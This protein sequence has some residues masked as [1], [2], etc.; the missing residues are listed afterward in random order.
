MA[1]RAPSS[2]RTLSSQDGVDWPGEH[3]EAMGGG[4]RCLA[5]GCKVARRQ[6]VVRKLPDSDED[7]DYQES[8]GRRV[9]QKWTGERR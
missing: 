2:E 6:Q 5:G 7:V 8:T 4:G 3:Q 1:R 9:G